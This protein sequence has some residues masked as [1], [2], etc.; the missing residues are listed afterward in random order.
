LGRRIEALVEDAF[1]DLFRQGLVSLQSNS[2]G[3]GWDSFRLSARGDA[4]LD[5][6]LPFRFHDTATYEEAVRSRVPRIDTKTITYLREA[7]TCFYSGS[8]LAATVMLGVA[9]E[10][11]F[12]LLADAATTSRAF[13]T[14][15]SKVQQESKMARKVAAFRRALEANRPQMS[16]SR[17]SDGT[18]SQ[19]AAIQDLIRLA[20]NDAGHAMAPAVSREVAYN[21]LRLFIPFA[22]F[23]TEIADYLRGT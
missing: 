7:A 4:E 23:A 20:R 19:F 1:W 2:G 14:F 18:D 16:H 17:I 11:E 12:L 8:L 22:E 9:A 5:L 21:Y 15:F 10:I 6:L 13:G 3:A